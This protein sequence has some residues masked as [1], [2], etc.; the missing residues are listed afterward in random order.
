MAI[1]QT[2]LG[3]A[4]PPPSPRGAPHSHNRQ[5]GYKT[6]T[7]PVGCIDSQFGTRSYGWRTSVPHTLFF[8]SP[9]QLIPETADWR[10]G[11][12]MYFFFH[13]YYN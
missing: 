12:S 1:S 4:Q 5:V 7:N 10:T 9:R 2:P 3:P 6:N 13:L 8:Q 11:I